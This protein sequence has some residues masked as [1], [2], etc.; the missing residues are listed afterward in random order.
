[1]HE[2]SAQSLQCC[3]NHRVVILA[4][5]QSAR[6]GVP[7]QLVRCQGQPLLRRAVLLALSTQPRKVMVVVPSRP[8]ALWQALQA[9]VAD[10]PVVL[11]V[12]LQPGQGIASSLQRAAAYLRVQLST[13]EETAGKESHG[14]ERLL[15]MLV[16]QVG[17]SPSHLQALLQPIGTQSLRVSGYAGI[18]GVPANVPL[19]WFVQQAPDLQAHQGLRALWQAWPVTDFEVIEQAALADEIDTPD[20]LNRLQARYQLQRPESL[21]NIDPNEQKLWQPIIGYHQDE[22]QHWVAELGCGHYQHVR[23]DPPWQN[24]IW[25]TTAVGR[26]SRWG[27]LLRCVRCAQGEPPQYEVSMELAVP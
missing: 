11:L 26:E 8:L 5:G 2:S 23:H 16:D 13:T 1:M 27:H 14:A 22:E 15:V 24:R 7:K 17:L 20:D 18:R 12:N 21:R 4:A 6:L 3:S 10:L 25:V 9:E 19:S